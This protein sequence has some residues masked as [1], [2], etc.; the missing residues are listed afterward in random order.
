MIVQMKILKKIF[1]L[2]KREINFQLVIV[3]TSTGRG[4]IIVNL[5]KIE[6]DIEFNILGGFKD[7]R[8][9]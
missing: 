4:E 7:D 8:D 5:A 6:Q 9:K 1:K 3:D 2:K